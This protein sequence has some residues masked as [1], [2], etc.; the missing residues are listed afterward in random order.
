ML[1]MKDVYR[2][3]TIFFHEFYA[4]IID[5]GHHDADR[6]FKQIGDHHKPDDVSNR[7]W[8]AKIIEER[9]YAHRIIG[10]RD[11]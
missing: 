9:S 11:Q 6:Y 4:L 3:T 7:Q 1:L 8:D 10:L 5:W 2:R